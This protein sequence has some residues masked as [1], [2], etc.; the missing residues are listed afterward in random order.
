[1][2]EREHALAAQKREHFVCAGMRAMSVVPATWPHL[3]ST[4]R[5]PA[6]V[7]SAPRRLRIFM[8]IRSLSM[9]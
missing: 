6:I 2:L 8:P 9:N 1:M 3:C 7:L 5:Q 4:A